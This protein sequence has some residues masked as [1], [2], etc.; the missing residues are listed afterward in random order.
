MSE[1]SQLHQCRPPDPK[2]FLLS[3]ILVTA[4]VWMRVPVTAP[5][6][7]RGVRKAVVSSFI[8]NPTANLLTLYGIASTYVSDYTKKVRHSS[9][10]LFT[11]RTKTMYVQ[12]NDKFNT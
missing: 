10:A 3:S 9:G 8:R 7:R 2:R 1:P 11:N 6:K 12:Q 4:A 5:H